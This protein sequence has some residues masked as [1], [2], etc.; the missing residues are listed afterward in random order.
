MS[1]GLKMNSQLSHTLHRWLIDYHPMQHNIASPF[2]FWTFGYKDLISDYSL[3]IKCQKRRKEDSLYTPEPESFRNVVIVLN[4]WDYESFL[5]TFFMS[6]AYRLLSFIFIVSDL[7]FFADTVG[8][9][10]FP[11]YIVYYLK[12]E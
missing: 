1:P 3:F 11:C 5:Y 12:W 4:D 2:W 9:W 10:K 8:K 6:F 7:C